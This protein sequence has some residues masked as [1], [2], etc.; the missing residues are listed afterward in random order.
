MRPAS[1]HHPP[2]SCGLAWR[3]KGRAP[4]L[5][6]PLS[7]VVACTYVCAAARLKSDEVAGVPIRRS[8]HCPLRRLGRD[9][10]AVSDAAE[11]QGGQPAAAPGLKG[12]GL[13]RGWVKAHVCVDVR[14]PRLAAIATVRAVV[15]K[16]N[17][18]ILAAGDV[19][20]IDRELKEI[21]PIST[22]GRRSSSAGETFE[23]SLFLDGFDPTKN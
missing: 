6:T 10:A 5:K 15:A 11:G 22:S 20:S 19:S 3:D 8:A 16:S 17:G 18:G 2:C 1:L 12:A 21:G 9:G 4:R 23:M 13:P 14:V 7:T